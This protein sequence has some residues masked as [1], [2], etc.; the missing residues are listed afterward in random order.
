MFC[1]RCPK[2][3]LATVVLLVVAHTAADAHAHE[4]EVAE[5]SCWVCV[6][7]ADLAPVVVAPEHDSRLLPTGQVSDRAAVALLPAPHTAYLA[8]APPFS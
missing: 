7:A 2:L 3:G 5:E 8:R 4:G 1:P 6:A